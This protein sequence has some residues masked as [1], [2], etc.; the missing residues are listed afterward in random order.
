MNEMEFRAFEQQEIKPGGVNRLTTIL[1]SDFTSFPKKKRRD[2][3]A[4]G[5]VHVIRGLDTTPLDPYYNDMGLPEKSI[6]VIECF[7]LL[8]QPV[9]AHGTQLVH[10]FASVFLTAVRRLPFSS[11]YGFK[12][13]YQAR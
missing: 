1:E 3:I 6:D 7:T 12:Q 10:W 4:D 13:P 5:V 9:Y 11:G 2:T 8:S